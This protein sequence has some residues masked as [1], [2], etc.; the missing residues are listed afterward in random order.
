MQI[1]ISNVRCL[2]LNILD[3]G[4]DLWN[5]RLNPIFLAVTKNFQTKNPKCILLAPSNTEAPKIRHQ[6]LWLCCPPLQPQELLSVICPPPLVF[7]TVSSSLPFLQFLI[8]TLL[9]LTIAMCAV[10][11]RCGIDQLCNTGEWKELK[12]LDSLV[13]LSLQN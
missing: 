4:S 2:R 5:L 7:S 8:H 12:T 6:T 1:E 11:R 10:S 13:C 3:Q 9:M